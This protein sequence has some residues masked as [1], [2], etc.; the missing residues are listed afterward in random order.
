MIQLQNRNRINAGRITLL[1]AGMLLSAVAAWSQPGGK[2]FQFLEMTN[3][4]RIGALGGDAV[5]IHDK[6]PELAYHNPSLLNPEM[7][8]HMALNYVNYF[9][10]TNFGYATAATKTGPKGMLAGGIHYLYYG[11][12]K[13]Y[14]ENNMATGKFKAADYSVNIMYSRP[15]DSLITYGFTVKSVYSDYEAYNATALAVD[16]GI[17][18]YNPQSKLTIGLAFRNLGFQVDKY[19][20]E[21]SQEPLPFN[22]ALGL[23]K[24]LEHAPLTFY[25]V[26]NHLEKWDLTYTTQKE[27]EDKEDNEGSMVIDGGSSESKFDKLVDKSMRHFVVGA[28]FNMGQNLVFRVGYNYRRRQELKIEDKPGMVGFSWGAGL[29]LNKFRISYGRAIYHLAGGTNQFSFSM[30]LDEFYKKF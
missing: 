13:G 3:S 25:I 4:A 11:T 21:G 14:D 24:S 2:A 28:E 12:F 6:D 22:I 8:H 29:N 1:L 16:A 5:A 19:Y 27:R 10:G 15:L 9:A 23:S 30:N 17:T 18:Y 7:H 20:A 26:I